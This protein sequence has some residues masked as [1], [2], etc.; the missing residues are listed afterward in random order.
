MVRLLRRLRAR[1]KYRDFERDL[2]KELEVHRAMKQDELEALGM[3]APDARSKAARS[4]GN[5]TYMREDA[6]SIWIARWIDQGW[7]DARYAVRQL[8][9]FPSYGIG[10]VLILSIGV[11]T[12]TVVFSTV[13]ATLLKPWPVADPD[14]LV[15]VETLQMPDGQFNTIS[16]AESRYLEDHAT[17]VGNL[18]TYMRGESVIEAPRADVQSNTVSA[19]Y[20]SAL[21]INAFLGRLFT[22]DDE[23]RG[24]AAVALISHRL[25]Q[26]A[27]EADP[28]VIGRT[29]RTATGFLTIVGVLEPGFEDVHRLR[30]DLWI[31]ATRSAGD[32]KPVNIVARLAEG[33]NTSRAASEL[34]ELSRQF[35]NANSL[36]TPELLV[37]NTRPINAPGN[38]SDRSQL[39]LLFPALG[40]LMLLVCANVGGLI[41]A[42]TSA[43]LREL[44]VRRALGASRRRVSRQV[45]TEVLMMAL[46]AGFLGVIGARLLPYTLTD[47]MRSDQFTP[48]ASVL[49]VAFALSVLAAVIAAASALLKVGRIN[50]STFI[51]R[52][53]GADRS[54]ARARSALI[55]T[56]LAI[57]AAVLTA[58]GLLTRAVVHASAADPG[59]RVEGLEF[60]SLNSGQMFRSTSA[61]GP[62]LG[63]WMQQSER[64]RAEVRNLGASIAFASHPP[65]SRS[66][67]PVPVRRTSDHPSSRTLISSRSVSSSYFDVMGIRL[68]EGRTLANAPGDREIVVSERAAKWL[69]P[70]EAALGRQLILKASS[71]EQ[72]YT[73]VGVAIDVATRTLGSTEPTIYMGCGL[74]SV[75]LTR[76]VEPAFGTQVTAVAARVDPSLRV[77]QRTVQQNLSEEGTSDLEDATTAA[78]IVGLS[79]LALSLI[80]AF[81]VLA[82]TVEERRRE[83]GIRMALGGGAWPVA[84][85]VMATANR[86]A[87][88]GIAAGAV[89]AALVA[90]LVR[91]QVFGLTPL[92]PIAYAMVLLVLVPPIALAAAVPARR[93]TR[94]DPAVT[95]RH[96]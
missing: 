73:V 85:S 74:C 91:H 21:R 14:S 36:P 13:N 32:L 65:L 4:L 72:T 10:A 5:V 76:N 96:D 59:F 63:N 23:Q 87:L 60:F 48:D 40:L 75:L 6:R 43:R 89:A 81:G 93:A 78:W 84:L 56:Q 94:I 25:W 9:R 33:V 19:S 49:A 79:A 58:A 7:Q 53:H 68:V 35:R 26:S 12:S 55:A 37:R 30:T 82:Y 18:A 70:S 1:F 22:H 83:I 28:N 92:D 11:A 52:Q 62:D 31:P 20:F 34:Q 45:F 50:V 95:L 42:R 66:I 77:I 90:Q 86:P 24:A 27:F 51:A 3:T 47:R 16:A 44:A 88:W 46:C 29:V 80:G 69:W 41:L 71:G 64:W 57:S 2:A 8:R 39:F 15:L 67:S 38:R 54:S 17:T 61:G